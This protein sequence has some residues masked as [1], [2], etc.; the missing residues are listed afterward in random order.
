[1]PF[2]I[3]NFEPDQPH[4]L[5]H[6][7]PGTESTEPIFTLQDGSIAIFSSNE[8]S[9]QK[10]CVLLGESAKINGHPAEIR[11]LRHGDRIEVSG[12]RYTYLDF[13]PQD[14][15]SDQSGKECSSASCQLKSVP[16]VEEITCPWCG[17]PYHR[18]CW[19]ELEQCNAS[20]AHYPVLRV[21]MRTLGEHIQIKRIEDTDIKG[22]ECSICGEAIKKGEYSVKCP[23]CAQTYHFGCWI[24][25]EECPRDD[26]NYDIK[27]LLS[28]TVFRI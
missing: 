13:I 4:E 9:T 21:L 6:P 27:D 23:A 14:V 16:L 25:R 24:S 5:K 18:G 20:N 22:Y 11:A 8:V 12:K 7:S 10:W 15:A 19:L 28:K 17:S 26:C 1:M 2:L 3:D